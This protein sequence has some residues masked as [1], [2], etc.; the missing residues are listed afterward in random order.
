LKRPP[1]VYWASLWGLG[2][3]VPVVSIAGDVRGL[4]LSY[5]VGRDFSNL[6]V[7]GKLAR[8]GQLWA[9][10]NPDG[11][12]V[13]LHDDLGIISMQNYSYPPHA[14]FIALPFSLLPYFVALA[15]WTI[16]GVVFF[17]WCARPYLAEGFRSWWAVL[18]PAAGINIWNGHYGFLFGGLWLLFFLDLTGQPRRAGLW[19]GLLTFKP[20]MGLMVVVAALRDRRTIL[21]AI[22][23]L[24]ALVGA[25][26]VAFGPDVWPDFFVRTTAEQ[27]NILTRTTGDFYF[28]MM[29]S[30]YVAFGHGLAGIGAQLLFAGGAI[31]LLARRRAADPFSYATATF[32]IVP[33]SFNYDM[34]VACLGF[35]ILL[36]RD[37]SAMNWRNRIF[38]ST[39]FLSPEL[40]YFADWA[41]P[42]ALLGALHVQ[43]LAVDDLPAAS[44]GRA[45]DGEEA[46]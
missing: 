3:A 39:A 36:H 46:G 14:L 7:A 2:A 44:R 20:H 33:Y 21:A 30:A 9:I 32:L 15:L 28:R 41:V 40:T 29:P 10:F 16:V 35:A 26:A 38:L 37:W 31:W 34:T 23:T 27:A 45:A 11:F 4:G 24:A 13:A 42:V 18:T 25:T 5:V 17:A 43:T 8:S 1:F 22:A 6:W 19:A 12:R